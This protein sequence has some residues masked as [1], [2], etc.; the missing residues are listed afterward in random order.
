LEVVFAAA[1][2]RG[3][4]A[5]LTQVKGSVAETVLRIEWVVLA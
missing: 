5:E 1:A 2:T 4:S 3:E